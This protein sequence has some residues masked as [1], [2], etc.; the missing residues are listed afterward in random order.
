LSYDPEVEKYR[1]MQKR[2]YSSVPA[3]DGMMRNA[4]V[5]CFDEHEKYPY[6]K[7][8]LMDIAPENLP[9]MVALDF[10][11]GPG[12]MILRLAPLFERV[13]GVDI[14]P[15][16]IETADRWTQYLPN[17]PKLY[18]N[19]G[20]V[21]DGIPD[22]AYDFVYSTIAFHHI[23]SYQV[24]MSLL[25]EFFRV[26]KPGGKFSIQFFYTTTP[27]E[28]W[29]QHT[30]WRESNHDAPSTNGY[31]DVRI[32]PDNLPEV[33]EDL[34]SIGFKGSIHALAPYPPPPHPKGPSE[35]DW[36]FIY[37]NKPA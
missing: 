12:R 24:R 13:D 37:G 30:S 4:V 22:G 21:L 19:D 23:N 6:E 36:V 15:T 33:M 26:L 10:G 2:H 17:R 35:T 34:E 28:Q 29:G 18:V 20:V 8:L 32:T 1:Q 9:K 5:G 31:H 11:C 25:R 3:H 14:S 16:C 27:R 7:F